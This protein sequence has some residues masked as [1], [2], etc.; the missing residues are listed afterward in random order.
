[1]DV[2]TSVMH[3]LVHPGVT[4]VRGTLGGM[5]GY[6]GNP[7]WRDM[8]DFVVHFTKDYEGRSASSGGVVKDVHC[9][10]GTGSDSRS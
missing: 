5:M 1:M 10:R 2:M 7:E 8:S 6:R 3:A 4:T 9:K